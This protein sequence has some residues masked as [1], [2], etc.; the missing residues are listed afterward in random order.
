[1]M[2]LHNKYS[3]MNL[4]VCLCLFFRSWIFGPQL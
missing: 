3:Q 4:K 1:M 2:H